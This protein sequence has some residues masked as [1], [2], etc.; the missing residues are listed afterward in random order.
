MKKISW[1]QINGRCLKCGKVL[2]RESVLCH[3][4]DQEARA[5]SN[6]KAP[7]VLIVK[8]AYKKQ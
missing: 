6:K 7:H 8:G 1:K 3:S 5:T 2:L 4:C